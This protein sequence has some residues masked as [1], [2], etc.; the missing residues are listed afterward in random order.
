MVRLRRIS[1]WLTSSASWPCDSGALN[2]PKQGG[3]G[4]KGRGVDDDKEPEAA[5][6]MGNQGVPD[7]EP[8]NL[9]TGPGGT[10][11][12][13]GKGRRVDRVPGGD[14]RAAH[15]SARPHGRERQEGT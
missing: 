8:T 9:R 5:E 1:C 4:V 6:N 10:L 15:E 13:P 14:S 11:R 3:V 12:P 2:S 7:E